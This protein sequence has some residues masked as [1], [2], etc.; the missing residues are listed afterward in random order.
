[1]GLSLLFEIGF[2]ELFWTFAEWELSV[3]VYAC[4]AV[5]FLIQAL[6]LKCRHRAVK[7]A[8][9]VLGAVAL[10]ACELACHVITAWDILAVLFLYGAVLC[11]LL[12]A[13]LAVLLR[14]ILK[15]R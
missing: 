1:M 13:V 4:V 12:G 15:K 6:L 3:M 10:V 5:G 9:L 8:F 14:R 7:W 2:L 11:L